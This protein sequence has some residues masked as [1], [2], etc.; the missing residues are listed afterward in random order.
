[1]ILLI[2]AGIVNI[3]CQETRFSGV[4]FYVSSKICCP[5]SLEMGIFW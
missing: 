1:M 3:I 4:V 5:M 2:A